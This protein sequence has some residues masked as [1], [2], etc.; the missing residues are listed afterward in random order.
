MKKYLF[1]IALISAFM[2]TSCHEEPVKVTT[3]EIEVSDV[4][5]S[6]AVVTVTPSD[7]NVW[8]YYDIIP[9]EYYVDYESTDSLVQD[10]IEWIEDEVAYCAEYGLDYVFEDWM[11]RGVD[12]YSYTDLTAETEYVAFAFAVDTATHQ[13]VGP[14]YQTKFTTLPVEEVSLMFEFASTD[15][16][17]WFLPNHNDVSYF[18]CVAPV[19]TLA[20]HNMTYEQ[21]WDFMVG[22]Y[23]EYID[24]LTFT[25]PVY[26]H[27]EYDGLIRGANYY[28]MAR[29]RDGGEW[30]S[31]LFTSQFIVPGEATA[32]AVSR[33]MGMKKHLGGKRVIYK[34][35]RFTVDAVK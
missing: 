22:Y 7:T 33:V 11:S 18:M 1:L 8:Y 30:N 3:F 24:Y 17:V 13:K 20:A 26:L 5:A 34:G 2:F 10:Y 9:T 27:Y 28:F 6:S 12:S 25:G 32:P 16:A 35:N 21:Y 23:G 14:F 15:T 19:D 4:T 29:A 31:D